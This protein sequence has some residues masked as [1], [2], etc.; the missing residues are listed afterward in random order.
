MPSSHRKLPPPVK[1]TGTV[2][3]CP[4]CGRKGRAAKLGTP[5]RCGECGKEFKAGAGGAGRTLILILL[6]IL[7]VAGLGY[8]AVSRAARLDAEA[9]V[10]AAAEERQQQGAEKGR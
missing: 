5:V 9:K 2:V 4:V 7:A 3:T 1:P 8:F 6:A 10:K